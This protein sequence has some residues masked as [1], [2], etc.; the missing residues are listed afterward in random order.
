MTL[1]LTIRLDLF[2]VLF[3]ILFFNINSAIIRRGQIWI[4]PNLAELT[5]K[6]KKV[7]KVYFGIFRPK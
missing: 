1:K 7:R 4:Q 6:N 3:Y 5:R 2:L